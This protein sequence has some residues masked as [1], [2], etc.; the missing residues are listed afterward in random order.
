MP[1]SGDFG[2]GSSPCEARRLATT[3]P[4]AP[5]TACGGAAMHE[6]ILQSIGRTPLVKLG[7]L[8][9]GLQ[10]QVAVKVESQNPG[11]SVKDRVAL[12]MI[13]DAARRGHLRPGGSLIAAT[14]GR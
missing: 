12:A 7:R 1:I 8:A 10:A 2:T 4:A 14:A 6:T 3:I 11:G 9:V 13:G 5:G